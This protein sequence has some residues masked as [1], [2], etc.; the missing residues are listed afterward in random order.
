VR[1]TGRN[2]AAAD[3]RT[4]DHAPAENGGM[5][6]GVRIRHARLTL[7]LRLQD[8]AGQVGCSESMLSKIENDR[9]LPSLMML[10]RIAT[11]LQTTVGR[12]CE[13]AGVTDNVVS[14]AGERRVVTMDP[15]RQG[16]GTSL[17]RLI[18]YDIAHLLQGN[19]HIVE[20]GGGSDG[21]LSHEG[22]EVGFVLEG[23]LELIVGDKTYALGPEDSFCFRSS[24]PHGYRNPGPGRARVLFINTPPSF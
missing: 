20:E 17:E 22:E 13:T 16:T 7:G 24:I 5:K 18:P 21:T 4:G 9:A 11:A 12:L 15:L 19:I 23:H 2:G 8:V 1:E 10:H 3:T 6:L 14:R